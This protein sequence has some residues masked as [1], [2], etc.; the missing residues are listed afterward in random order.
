MEQF[1][2]FE[3]AIYIDSLA[4]QL[5]E[6]VSSLAF[7]MPPNYDWKVIQLIQSAI[8]QMA[9]SLDSLLLTSTTSEDLNARTA[10]RK[11]ETRL[12][13]CT[14]QLYKLMVDKPEVNLSD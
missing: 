4:D 2:G 1:V 10:F 3:T 8:K 14:S 13:L 6:E 12:Y 7:M 5:N 11:L 9:E